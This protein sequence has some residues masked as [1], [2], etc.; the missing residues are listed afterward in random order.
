MLPNFFRINTHSH[1]FPSCLPSISPSFFQYWEYF[2][3]H[4]QPLLIFSFYF[5][6]R[7]RL[8]KLEGPQ[9]GLVIV[10]TLASQSYM[11]FFFLSKT[12][13]MLH[14]M[15]YNLLHFT[16]NH[17][18]WVFFHGNIYDYGLALFCPVEFLQLDLSPINFELLYLFFI[19]SNEA[20][21]HG[22]PLL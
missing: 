1:S 2:E 19:L 6:L 14:M 3:L 13:F 17:T 20:A 16:H 15:L 21:G 18:T 8:A 4:P 22:G 5:I 12:R 11:H 9:A 7:Q 10:L